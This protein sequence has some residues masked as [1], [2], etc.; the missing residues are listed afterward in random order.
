MTTAFKMT[1]KAREAARSLA[2]RYDA[3]NSARADGD[4]NGIAL[5]GDL[6]IESQEKVGV[7]LYRSDFIRPIVAEARQNAS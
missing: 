3:F 2:I 4:N 1:D 6:L 7:K 5:W